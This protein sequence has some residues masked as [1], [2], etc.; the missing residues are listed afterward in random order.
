MKAIVDDVVKH[1][2][3]SSTLDAY[4]KKLGTALSSALNAAENGQP[5]S[6]M[7]MV[8]LAQVHYEHIKAI[9]EKF[10]EDKPTLTNKE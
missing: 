1:G 9:W 7:A 3:N 5:F 4:L 8:G 10:N 6:A 2:I